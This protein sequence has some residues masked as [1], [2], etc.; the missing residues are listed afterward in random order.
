V[1]KIGKIIGL[2]ASRPKKFLWF[3]KGRG[4]NTNYG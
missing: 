4:K 3:S 1:I 2:F